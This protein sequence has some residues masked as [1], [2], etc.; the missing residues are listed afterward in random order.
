MAGRGAVGVIA[1]AVCMIAGTACSGHDL[2]FRAD[3]RVKIVSPA[4]RQEVSV[5]IDVRWDTSL[6]PVSAGGPS[7]AVFVDRPPVHRGQTLRSV[8]D[9]ACRRDP[10]CPDAQYLRDRNV[11]VTDGHS[12]SVDT[13]PKPSGGT[14]ERAT[15]THEATVILVGHGGRRIGEAA[16][17]VEFRAAST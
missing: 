7:F 8:G 10:S 17:S 15:G 4:S 3:R 5:P 1:M 2:A 12:V 11:Y 6:P 16:Y 14:R 9:D 13:V